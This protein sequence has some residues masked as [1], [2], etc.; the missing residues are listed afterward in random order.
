MNPIEELALSSLNKI[1]DNLWLGDYEKIQQIAKE[2]LNTPESSN[3][4][5][6]GQQGIEIAK[7]IRKAAASYNKKKEWIADN[8]SNYFSQEHISFDNYMIG[9]IINRLKSIIEQENYYVENLDE[10]EYANF[11][12]SVKLFSR[13]NYK[14]RIINR[15]PKYETRAIF[16]NKA[17]SLSD[18]DLRD[19][20]D[21]LSSTHTSHTT[22]AS[23]VLQ[24]FSNESF[25][26]ATILP[27]TGWLRTVLR[28]GEQKDIEAI[29]D[30]ILEKFS[31][32]EM[33]RKISTT[34]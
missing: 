6:F 9:L 30:K 19:L 27:H 21:S 10:G 12:A 5:K 7:N 28:T 16:E 20:A 32:G 14:F 17:K 26:E 34:V 15:H 29:S 24:L 8:I 31:G 11:K 3:F 13:T 2:L 33:E 22:K 23:T 18:A 1:H 25:I 4:L